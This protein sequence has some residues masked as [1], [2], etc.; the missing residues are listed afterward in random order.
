LFGAVHAE[1]SAIAALYR[2]FTSRFMRF[3]PVLLLCL[4]AT[5]CL[6]PEEALRSADEDVY[7]LIDQ[8][9]EALFGDLGSFRID[10]PG[11]SLRERFLSGAWTGAEPW[12][13]L[14]CLEIAAENSRG[15]HDER[16]G[17]Y[18][19]ALD[20]TLERWRYSSI[21]AV[22]GSGGASGTGLETDS[23]DADA[24]AS[25]SKL[26]GSGARIVTGIGA[27]LF[28][29]VRT[30]DGWEAASNL[31]LSITQP[32]LSGAGRA[33]V[34]EP[35]TQAERN[36]VYAVRRYERFRRTFGVDV[37]TRVYGLLESIDQLGNEERNYENLVSL[38]ERT[39][40]M[41][42]A[43]RISPIEAAEANQ[44]ELGSEN[45]LLSLRAN[46]E[47]QRDSFLLFL[48]LPIDLPFELDA[49]EFDR[50][51]GDDADLFALEDGVAEL[52]ALGQRLD[53]W[54]AED[55]LADAERQ[56]L[57]S[58][59]GLKAGLDLSVSANAASASG[60]PLD[61]SRDNLGWSA[62]LSLDLAVDRTPERNSYRRSVIRAVQANRD[63]AELRD[64]TRAD[65]RDA[66]RSARNT[67]A[68]YLIQKGA[69]TLAERRVEGAN[70]SLTAGRATTKIVLDAQEDLVDA[71]NAET[72][73]LIDFTLARLS[74]YLQV[75]ALRVDETGLRVDM[76]TNASGDK[77]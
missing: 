21:A 63:L 51:D 37:A 48:G 39:Q 28:R 33:I 2:Q 52:M 5:A 47:R 11:G 61:Y 67:R 8:R 7:A 22:G 15:F 32:L 29:L 65:I 14:Q 6:S 42:D 44:N 34:M 30:G 40:A 45:R 9:R 58:A 50:L 70:L 59:E 31:S 12:T 13:L 17:L 64:R 57:V 56:I 36:V 46:V 27:S 74:F 19:S 25:L 72:Q 20:L 55:Q 26:L 62:G 3:R 1:P 38:S 66:L 60:R 24:D 41:A 16:E 77:R 68:S 10:P 69:V 75:E 53:L 35:L 43:G 23:V 4:G 18:L 49:N 73:A 71:E 54:T 76:Q